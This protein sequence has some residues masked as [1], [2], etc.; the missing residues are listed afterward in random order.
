MGAFDSYVGAYLLGTLF[1]L[2]LTGI[3]WSQ[4]VEYWRCT[5]NER[6]IYSL[7]VYTILFFGFLHTG[8]SIATIYIMV[9]DNF[10]VVSQFARCPWP[11]AMD[12]IITAIIAFI[13]QTFFAYRVYILSNRKLVLPGF[14]LFLTL[15]Q[16]SFGAYCTTYAY[17]HPLWV[18]IATIKWAVALWLYLM[19]F[20]D[21]VI[22]SAIIYY[23][24]QAKTGFNPTNSVIDRII[25]H[26]IANNALTAIAAAASSIMF[27]AAPG[28]YHVIAGLIIARFYIVSFL[29]SLNSRVRLSEDLN[30]TRAIGR[31]YTS[32]LDSG[33]G[34]STPIPGTPRATMREGKPNRPHIAR[35]HSSRSNFNYGQDSLPIQVTIDSTSEQYIEED[36]E[37]WDSDKHAGG[38]RREAPTTLTPNNSPPFR[39][40]SLA[41]PENLLHPP[42]SGRTTREEK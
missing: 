35:S 18:E 25:K 10:G 12:P 19:A 20:G 42:S 38:H 11:F 27:V 7:A 30:T 13:A 17:L 6:W 40:L 2:F 37:M 33:M 14:I 3:N 15:L 29:G 8:T 24:N 26:I 41:V 32:G 31:A 5:Q 9:V 22:T 23:L 36:R 4:M 34:P 16:L 39:V 21:I 28:V 1:N